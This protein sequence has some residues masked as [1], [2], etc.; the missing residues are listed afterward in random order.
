MLFFVPAMNL[1]GIPPMSGFL[2]KVGLLQAG[3]D[4]RPLALALVVVAGGTR[5][6]C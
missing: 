3:L 4:G 6:A 5:P 1:A 2:G